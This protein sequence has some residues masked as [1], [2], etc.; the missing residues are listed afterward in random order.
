MFNKLFANLQNQ[1]INLLGNQQGVPL[2]FLN[3]PQ[4]PAGNINQLMGQIPVQ[5]AQQMRPQMRG[6]QAALMSPLMEEEDYY[7]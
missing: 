2:D 5:Q 6:L 7:G 1:G 3:A 4:M